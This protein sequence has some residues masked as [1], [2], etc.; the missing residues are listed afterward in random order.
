[1]TLEVAFLISS[2]EIGGSKYQPVKVSCRLRTKFLKSLALAAPG[3][4]GL[5]SGRV[6]L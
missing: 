6:E 5:L 2:N 4:F 3:F 1:M